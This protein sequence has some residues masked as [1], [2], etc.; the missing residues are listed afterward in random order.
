MV[1]I[2]TIMISMISCNKDELFVEEKEVVIE[3]PTDTDDTDNDDDDVNTALPCDFTLENIEPN[4]TIIINCILDLDGKTVDL[5]ANVTINYEGGDIINGTINFSEGNIIDGN[6]LNSSLTIGGSTPQ[7][8]DPVFMFKPER[9]GIVQGKVSDEVA[10]NNTGLLNSLITKTKELG[11]TTFEIDEM[12][13]YFGINVDTRKPHAIFVPSD[14]NLVMSDNTNLR[15][16]PNGLTH[17]ALLFSWE[18]DNV[19]ISG[20]KLWGDR[21]KHDYNSIS[22]SHEWGHTI[23]FKAV[24]NGVVDNVEMHEGTGDG[25]YLSSSSDRN[26]DGSLKPDRRE[27]FNI[28]VKNCLINDNR[29][30]NISIVDG[31]DVFIEYNTIRNG[32]GNNGTS[33]RVGV[34]IESREQFNPD[35]TVYTWEKTEN[36]HI[37]HNVFEENI[38]ADIVLLSGE[39]AYIYGNTFRSKRA[40]SVSAA[41][42]GKV[43]DNSFERPEG[44]M[45]ESTGLNLRSNY[46]ANGVHRVTNYEVTNNT[47]T[48][49]QHAIMAGGQNNKIKNNTITNCLRGISLISSIDIEF[50]D[51]KISSDLSKSYGYYTFSDE[52]SIKNCLIANGETNVQ[53][54]ELYFSNKNNDEPGDIII[55]N[56]DFNGDIALNNAQNITV[57]NSTFN[58]IEIKNCTPTLTNNN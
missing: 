7:V 28:T 24:H 23:F 52:K 19:L 46:L 9:W 30:D 48:G 54:L 27:S 11:A 1:F 35:G 56:V 13:A 25:F 4:S 18:V 44:L 32:G 38:A 37:R 49:Y 26:A 53:G 29:R 45:S 10:L 14:F 2:L 34:I 17:Y 36:V 31:K 6:L 50:D 43:Y 21:Y 12:D 16:Q 22:S 8:K 3:E 20:G 5:P 42:D 55:D 41:V 58:D 57:K 39:K 33:P 40:V 15:V 47:F 51:N